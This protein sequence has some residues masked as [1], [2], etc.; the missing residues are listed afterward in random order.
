LI[1]QPLKN[2]LPE[3]VSQPGARCF[4]QRAFP[5]SKSVTAKIRAKI[6]PLPKTGTL[7]A[8]LSADK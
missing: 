5:F 6:R 4:P 2:P 7:P 8:K 3:L 1:R